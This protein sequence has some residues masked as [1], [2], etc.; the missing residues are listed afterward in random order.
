MQAAPPRAGHPKLLPIREDDAFIARA[1]EDLSVPT[2]MMSMIHMSGDASLLDGELR[3]QGCLLNE[4]QGFMSEAQQASVRA[5]ALD[6]IRA[7]RDRDAS[8]PPPPPPTPATI[9]RMM[10]F[11]AAGEVPENYVPM[12]LEEMELDGTDARAVT[13][14]ELAAPEE[15]RAGFH[16]L[17]IGCGMSGLLAAIRL[18]QAGIPYTVLEKNS[19]LGGTW[20]ENR[21]P[22]CRVDVGNHFYCY[23][24]EPNHDWSEFFARQP[25]LLAYFEKC[26][27]KYGVRERVRFNTEVLGAR[28]HEKA[29]RWSV[30]VR[31]ADGREQTLVTNAL[32]SAVGQLNRA[33]IPELPGIETFTGPTMHSSAWRSDVAW[34]GKRV[35]VI[36]A[37]ASAF[38]I[39]PSIAAEAAQV[40]VFQRSAQWMFP[41]PNYH[42]KVGAGKKWALEHLPGYARWYRFYLFWPGCDGG[43]AAMRADPDYPH[44]ERAV[45]EA[46]EAARV[47]FTNY[48]QEQVKGDA[49]LFEK[50]VPDYVCLGKRTLQDNGSWLAALQRENVQLVTE[51]IAE[52]RESDL[53]CEDERAYRADLI[54][55]ATG[56]HANRFLW[57]MEITGRG[58]VKLSEQWGDAPAAYL[59]ITAPNFP[60][61]FCIYGPGT[62][63]AHAGS[64]IFHSECQVRYILGC[65]RALLTSEHDAI[66]CKR[67]VHDEYNERLQKELAGMVWSH[68][69]IRSS[70]YK[71]KAGRVTVLSPWP[72]RDYWEW[73][74]APQLEDFTL[75]P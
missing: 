43:L 63:L 47:A 20:Y 41:N 42:A 13:A 21:Y 48:L 19:G 8:A 35:A 75:S 29:A 68:P 40:A 14:A 18:E 60:N 22:G 53:V 38:Q 7:Y 66:E 31:G 3:P 59:G 1:L 16:V 73:T 52:V 72:L 39:V 11:L 61:L 15:K 54:V 25:E 50:V 33:K 27:S 56:F 71:N 10:N 9:H 17:V 2:L 57:P 36:G 49:E 4:V 30:R 32:I 64:I 26:A 58:G 65:L 74:R 44:P 55:Y 37:G 69:S 46:N 5:A 24:F 28:W 34:R 45:S 62:N 70:W 23:S 12:M 6:V 67:K 51:P